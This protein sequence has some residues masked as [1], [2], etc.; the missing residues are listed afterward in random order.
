MVWSRIFDKIA[1]GGQIENEDGQEEE[2]KK[3]VLADFFFEFLVRD[4]DSFFFELDEYFF[5]AYLAF[6]SV[7]EH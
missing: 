3:L 7:C 5:F 1:D 2:E 6:Y 4:A